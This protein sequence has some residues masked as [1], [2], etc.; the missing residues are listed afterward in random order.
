MS[1]FF[2][3]RATTILEASLDIILSRLFLGDVSC[4]LLFHDIHINDVA[5]KELFLCT[6][7]NNL[8]MRPTGDQEVAG[9][10]PPGR[11]H[12]FMEIDH[13]LFS[14]NILSLPLVQEGQLSVSGERMCTLLANR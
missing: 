5:R 3:L 7:R 8:D 13:E 14:T 1:K 12:F 11:Q 9:S 2:S 10:A 4:F 6:P